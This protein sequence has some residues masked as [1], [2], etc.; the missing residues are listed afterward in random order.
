MKKVSIVI[1]IILITLVFDTKILGDTIYNTYS[2]Y[3][4]DHNIKIVSNDNFLKTNKYHNEDISNTIKETEDYLVDNKSEL[5][6][7]YYTAV[8]NG[9]DSLTFYCSKEYINCM[10]DINKLDSENNDFSIVN[11]LVNVY[12]TYEFIESSYYSNK[13]VDIKITKR[14]SKEDIDKID[15]KIN[16]L[17]NE[18]GINNYD[19]I[20]DKIKVFHDYIANTNTYDQEMADNGKS[21][22]HSNSAIGTLFEG[23]SVCSGYT[24]AMSLFLDKLKVKNVRIATDKHVWN[25]IYLDGNWYHLDLTWDDPVLSD[26]SNIIQYD[27]FMIT[28]DE[29]KKLD[30]DDHNFDKNT[31]SFI[32]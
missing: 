8:N 7:V 32:Y 10:E 29:L 17:I 13:R 11:Q 18:L 22:Y 5:I 27:Y 16:E 21:N 30:D 19:N 23:K 24:D 4:I 14:Y 28:T 31:Y 1:F 6:N 2:K 9:F 3:L 12:N 15:N 26:N 25:G 20:K